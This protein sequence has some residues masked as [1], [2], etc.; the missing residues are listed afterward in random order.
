MIDGA[1]VLTSRSGP[2]WLAGVSAV[3]PFLHSPPVIALFSQMIGMDQAG[4]ADLRGSSPRAFRRAFI[5][6]FRSGVSRVERT[7]ESPTLLVAG[8]K[9]TAVRPSNAALAELMPNAQARYVPGVGH[10][11]L[12]RRPEL[13]VA[14]VEAW[15]TG[16]ELPP[17][18]VPEVPSPA[19]VT[20]L[21]RELGEPPHGSIR[22]QRR[23]TPAA[24][25]SP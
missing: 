12:A 15:L 25:P 7:A 19:T 23:S 21:R 22:R 8:E 1:G 9:E 18:L 5:E 11:W 4:R 13:H 3:S 17:E 16:A 24:R 6:G 14:M 2:A 10:G 20:R